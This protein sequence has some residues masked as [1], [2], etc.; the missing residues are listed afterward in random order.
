M[1]SDSEASFEEDPEEQMDTL[2]STFKE[3]KAK[4]N[5]QMKRLTDSELSLIS[6]IT[7]AGSTKF[8]VALIRRSA[9]LEKTKSN[10]RIRE[11]A[12]RGLKKREPSIKKLAIYFN[13]LVDS[14]ITAAQGKKEALD[15]ILPKLDLDQLYNP[16][17]NLHMWLEDKLP[18][19]FGPLPGY[20]VDPKV[21]EGIQAMLCLD[22]MK[23]EAERLKQ[24]RH[25]M[26][27]WVTSQVH[28]L[29]CLV[30][31]C[32]DETFKWHLTQQKMELSH[33]AL[34]WK[35]HMQ[36]GNWRL[37]NADWGVITG[38]KPTSN[39]PE[40]DSHEV[41]DLLDDLDDSSDDDGESLWEDMQ[42]GEFGMVMGALQLDE[43]QEVQQLVNA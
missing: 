12:Q 28:H 3:M 2:K 24:E 13:T 39:T 42:E 16:D 19:R 22:R 38:F 11:Q 5:K 40:L 20:I 7:S 23:E 29:D 31:A 34:L 43:E 36:T 25:T 8:K 41:E 14:A 26:I 35:H 10:N 33:H 30:A 18:G 15:L 21:R 37:G 1:D 27:Q 32:E 6:S 17:A 9:Q 4:L